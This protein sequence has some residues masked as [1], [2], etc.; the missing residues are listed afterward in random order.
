M[1]CWEAVQAE[2]AAGG[3]LPAHQTCA[4][5][6]S[7]LPAWQVAA[8]RHC[9][10]SLSVTCAFRCICLLNDVPSHCIS[11]G[12]LPAARTATPAMN[13]SS[14]MHLPSTSHHTATHHGLHQVY[15]S[16]HL[17]DVAGQLP[18]GVAIQLHALDGLDGLH[19]GLVPGLA[20]VG[21][22]QPAAWQRGMQSPAAN[23][24]ASSHCQSHAAY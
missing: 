10:S 22:G 23:E 17:I 20:L 24:A 14:S 4:P 5:H 8:R 18:E 19:W 13:A 1:H 9:Q 15:L 7:V 3:C 6:A 16:V 11:A 21:K 2:L 12:I